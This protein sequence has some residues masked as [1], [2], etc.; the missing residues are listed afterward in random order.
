MKLLYCMQA[1]GGRHSDSRMIQHWCGLILKRAQSPAKERSCRAKADMGHEYTLRTSADALRCIM[2][3][4]PAWFH[5]FL[6][7]ADTWSDSCGPSQVKMMA[8]KQSMFVRILQCCHEVQKA[9]TL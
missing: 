7:M 8:D 1:F 3:W 9:S 6:C 4:V 2:S 5:S